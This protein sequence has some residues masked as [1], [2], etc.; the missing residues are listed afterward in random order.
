MCTVAWGGNEFTPLLVMYRDTGGFSATVV[1]ALLAA[2][3]L[4]IVPALL[5]GGPLSDRYGRRPLLLPAPAV[6][7]AGSLVLAAGAEHELTLFAGRIL[8]GVSLGLVMAAGTPWVTELS[9]PP[10]D[11]PKPG[12]GPRRVSIAM[13]AGFALGAGVAGMLAQWGPWPTV[14]PY[15]AHV[16]ITIPAA[17][18]LIAVPET[19]PARPG[20]TTIRELAGDLRVPSLGHRR[21][22]FVVAPAAPWVF[23]CAASAYAIVPGLVASQTGGAPIAFSALLTVVTLGAGITVQLLGRRLDTPRN[24]RGVTLALVAT[25]VGMLVAAQ[26]ARTLDLGTALIAAAVLGAGYGLG[27]MSGLQEV[28]RIATA[29]DLGGL[30]AV[31][32]SLTY[33]GFF[34]PAML[35]VLSDRWDYSAMFTGGAI[36]ATGSCAVVVLAWRAHLPETVTGPDETPDAA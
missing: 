8:S 20:R 18:A 27:L 36:L 7:I 31:Y 2:Y 25:I 4:G 23:G 10:Y 5:L 6:A 3:V 1:Y 11:T 19:H 32:Y 16:A 30:T 12:R 15:L 17:L 21:F 13:T 24:A 9:E 26:T 29:H 34:V 35:S 14:T 33:L 28:R 22:W